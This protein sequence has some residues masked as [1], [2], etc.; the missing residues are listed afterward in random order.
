MPKPS[1][2]LT[3]AALAV[4]SVA[5]FTATPSLA[6][7]EGV[8]AGKPLFDAQGKRVGYIYRV[9]A[10]GSPQLIVEG[11]LITVPVSSVS[12]AGGKIVTSLT[13]KE[14]TSH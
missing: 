10:N 2:L 12:V 4:A 8:V 7:V 1:T 13:R 6:Q 5:A 3:A 14:L 11:K 9:S